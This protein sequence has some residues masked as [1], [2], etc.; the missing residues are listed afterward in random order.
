MVKV[1]S[2]IVLYTNT[3]DNAIIVIYLMTDL[4]VIIDNNHASFS[5]S[6]QRTAGS[7][8]VEAS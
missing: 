3:I 5:E 2:N 8:A 1:W 7:F 6:V 4:V